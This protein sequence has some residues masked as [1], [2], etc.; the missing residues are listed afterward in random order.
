[1]T[2]RLNLIKKPIVP[3]KES[4]DEEQQ[5]PTSSG[6]E[7]PQKIA[8]EHEQVKVKSSTLMRGDLESFDFKTNLFIKE[9]KEMTS[10]DGKNDYT[11]ILISTSEDSDKMRYFSFQLNRCEFIQGFR[12]PSKKISVTSCFILLKEGRDDA[13]IKFLLGLQA[14][15]KSFSKNKKCGFKEKDLEDLIKFDEDK[16]EEG[17][18][19]QYACFAK[20]ND[21]KFTDK[22]GEEKNPKTMC[23]IPSGKGKEDYYEIPYDHESLQ[24]YSFFGVPIIRLNRIVKAAKTTVDL[25][26]DSVAINK[27]VKYE[28]VNV[29]VKN[30]KEFSE[31][32]DDN[33][34]DFMNMLSVLKSKG[35]KLNMN[36]TEE[37]KS[38]I[39][40]S[41]K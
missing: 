6:S 9:V 16:Q 34:L 13:N 11:N 28:R 24:G 26:V 30:I 33:D 7:S 37:T 29:A 25:I 2:T 21:F 40:P 35:L 22:K 32:I 4:T 31:D 17:Q 27:L 41:L 12:P 36:H 15:L 1:M 3:E 10:K 8:H 5:N 20:V 38:E 19:K 14:H 23:Y 39:D 18:P